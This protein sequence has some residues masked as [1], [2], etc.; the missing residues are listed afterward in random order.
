MRSRMIWCWPPGLAL[1]AALTS[2]CG[3]SAST[4]LP[5]PTPA[6]P[7]QGAQ[8]AKDVSAGMP[9]DMMRPPGVGK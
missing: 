6:T 1:L 8:A 3:G 2:G 4:N 9:K 5:P 7:E